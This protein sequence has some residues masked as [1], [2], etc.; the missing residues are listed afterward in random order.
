MK[1]YLKPEEVATMA[2]SYYLIKQNPFQ[3]RYLKWT[4]E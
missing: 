3:D 1:G 2:V 4:T